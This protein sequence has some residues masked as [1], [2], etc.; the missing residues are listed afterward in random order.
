MCNL[1]LISTY[2][3]YILLLSNTRY[4]C[5]K[6]IRQHSYVH[7]WFCFLTIGYLA[8]MSKMEGVWT[9]EQHL[10]C[11]YTY[12]PHRSKAM[13]LSASN[14]RFSWPQDSHTPGKPSSY[15]IFEKKWK[16]VMEI[17]HLVCVC[18]SI[19]PEKLLLIWYHQNTNHQDRHLDNLE[20]LGLGCSV[21]SQKQTSMVNNRARCL[22]S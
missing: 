21:H 5:H 13:L 4:F 7:F 16:L 1:L 15:W 9:Q 12:L 2:N 11:W 14:R 8:I 22:N 17:F 18:S 10:S 6:I 3:V 19:V 20:V